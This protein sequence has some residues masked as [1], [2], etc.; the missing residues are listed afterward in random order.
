VRFDD[1]SFDAAYLITVIGQIPDPDQAMRE[2]H[3]VLK[4]GGTLA[5]SELLMD[6]DYPLA[7]TLIRKASATGFRLRER[8]GSMFAYT[9]VSEKAL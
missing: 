5:F 3:R 7:R 9:L 6:P 2:F 1:E 4:P 8:A